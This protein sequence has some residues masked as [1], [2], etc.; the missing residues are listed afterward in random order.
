MVCRTVYIRFML[1][2]KVRVPSRNVLIKIALCFVN[3]YLVIPVE[4]V[5]IKRVFKPE[6]TMYVCIA[7]MLPFICGKRRK[8]NL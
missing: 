7:P 4:V 2:S 1:F 8:G 3:F 6:E 5:D